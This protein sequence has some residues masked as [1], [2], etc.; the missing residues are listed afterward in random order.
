MVHVKGTDSKNSKTP[1]PKRVLL[2]A[3]FAEKV[4]QKIAAATVGI[5]DASGWIVVNPLPGPLHVDCGQDAVRLG[6]FHEVM[7][8]SM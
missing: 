1:K 6:G 2:K 8:A 7:A 4:A 3:F 5:L